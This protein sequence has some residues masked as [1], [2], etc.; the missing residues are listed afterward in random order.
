MTKEF[1]LVATDTIWA[2]TKHI[3]PLANPKTVPSTIVI[4]EHEPIS[5]SNN[6]K[7]YGGLTRKPGRTFVTFP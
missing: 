1:I 7:Q 6:E 4:N 3:A 5:S 2:T